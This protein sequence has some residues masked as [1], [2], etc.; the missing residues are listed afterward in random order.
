MI[1]E[2]LDIDGRMLLT[3]KTLVFRPGLLSLDYKNGKRVKYTPP[4]RIYL[5]I[6]ILFFLLVSTLDFSSYGQGVA[7][8]AVRSEYYPRIMFVLLPV[9][10]WL[11]HLF[12]KG[13]FYL[14]NLIFAIHIHCVSYLAW[15]IMLPLEAYEKTYPVFIYLQIPFAVYLLVYI[16]LAMKRFYEEGWAKVITKF[17]AIL[18]L[19]ASALGISFDYILPAVLL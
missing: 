11:L 7:D 19:Y 6:S 13:T 14:S 15:A 16:L 5:V 8:P 4:L 12:F 10:A 17:L 3:L 9:F 1:N 18:F 2:A